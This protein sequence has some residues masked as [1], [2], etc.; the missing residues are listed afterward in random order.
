MLSSSQQ[1]QKYQYP[2]ML[3]KHSRKRE[4][5]FALFQCLAWSCLNSSPKSTVKKCFLPASAQGLQ[6]LGGMS[7]YKY[8]G[9]DGEIVSMKSFGASAPAG[10]LFK[11]FGIT[12]EC[13][14]DAVKRVIG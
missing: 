1:A 5:M 4:S 12:S 3:R 14:A 2:L 13:V 7:W 6:A 10:E 9:L 11:H 8:T